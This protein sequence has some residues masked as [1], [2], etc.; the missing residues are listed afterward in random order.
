MLAT[1]NAQL[2]ADTFGLSISGIPG[3]KPGIAVKG[4]GQLIGGM[5]NPVGDGL[6]CTGPQQR[7]QVVISN[8]SGQATLTNW[9]GQPFGIGA[10]NNP[11]TPTYY[12]FWYR[13]P[14]NTCSG[15]GFNFTN[16]WCVNWN[17]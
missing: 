15:D 3:S 8:S 9:Q 1:G 11:G 12:Q 2:S 17:N 6:L 4:S 10:S 7:S 14:S 5:G 13:D 16:A